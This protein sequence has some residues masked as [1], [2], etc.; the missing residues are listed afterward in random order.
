MILNVSINV[1]NIL[2]NFKIAFP[3]KPLILEE[4]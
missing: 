3:K 4:L 2:I 1:M